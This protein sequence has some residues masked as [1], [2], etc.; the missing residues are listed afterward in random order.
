MNNWFG[1][2]NIVPTVVGEFEDSTLIKI[3]GQSGLGLF[4]MPTVEEGEILRQ[5]DVK[6]IGRLPGIKVKFYAIS[7]ERKVK[8]PA[9]LAIAETAHKSIFE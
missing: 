2:H 6:V 7:T 4:V 1:E 5:Y 8:N 9:V 3:F